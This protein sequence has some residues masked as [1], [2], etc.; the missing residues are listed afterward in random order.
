LNS[1]PQGFRKWP[2]G[3]QGGKKEGKERK[4]KEGKEGRKEEEEEDAAK[5]R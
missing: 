3:I 1:P 5:C 4:K 2:Q